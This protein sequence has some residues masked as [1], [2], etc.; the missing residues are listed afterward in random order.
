MR[1]EVTP[2]GWFVLAIVLA[3][4]LIGFA[5]ALHEHRAGRRSHPA[6]LAGS[7]G[8]AVAILALLVIRN[9]I[10]ALAVPTVV[11]IAGHILL[12]RAY[13]RRHGG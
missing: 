3:G 11:Y 6:L 12:A 13:R 4:C 10:V 5:V 1:L 9:P 7:A 2:L 8:A